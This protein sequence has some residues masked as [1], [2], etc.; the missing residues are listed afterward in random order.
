MKSRTA[1]DSDPIWSLSILWCLRT[2]TKCLVWEYYFS[3]DLPAAL[4]FSHQTWA[5][6]NPWSIYKSTHLAW[7]AYSCTSDQITICSSSTI[8]FPWSFSIAFHLCL[9][10]LIFE[11]IQIWLTLHHASQVRLMIFSK[12][13]EPHHTRGRWHPCLLVPGFHQ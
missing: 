10:E 6:A 3:E 5:E 11:W 4:L 9:F 12:G 2:T 1:I 8:S 7:V 13:V